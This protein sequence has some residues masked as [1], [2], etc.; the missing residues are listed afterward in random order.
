[1]VDVHWEISHT[2][3]IAIRI[4]GLGGTDSAHAASD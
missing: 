1:V 2:A 3:S 4:E